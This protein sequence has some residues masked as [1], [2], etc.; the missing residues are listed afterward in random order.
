MVERDPQGVARHGHPDR[1]GVSRVRDRPVVPDGDSAR[2]RRRRTSSSRARS[3][4]RTAWP[5]MRIG[6]A[7]GMAETIKQLAAL[8]M[9]Y[10]VSVFGVAAAIAALTTRSTSRTSAS[11]TPRSARSRSRRCEDMGCQAGR[12]AGQL[13]L[14]RHRPAGEGLPRRLRQAGRH[15]RPRLPAVREDAT[16]RISIGT[17]DEM[18]KAAECSAAC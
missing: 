9:P 10:N 6:Y 14:R 15:G 16:A 12:L 5:G 2:A 13:H 11:A 3:R 4:R 17:M 8:K 7:I 1:R 18:K